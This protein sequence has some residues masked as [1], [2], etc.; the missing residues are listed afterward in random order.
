MIRSKLSRLVEEGEQGTLFSIVACV[1]V[2]SFI[3]ATTIFNS[4]YPATLYFMKGFPFLFGAIVLL[5]PAG[6]IGLLEFFGLNPV[7]SQFAEIS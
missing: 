1:E 5:I 4:L 7:Y 6:V 3:L 2:F